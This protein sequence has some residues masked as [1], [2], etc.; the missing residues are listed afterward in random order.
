MKNRIADF[1]PSAWLPGIAGQSAKKKDSGSEP[2]S[3]LDPVE[4]LIAKHPAAALAVAFAA[5][6]ALAWWIKRK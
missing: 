2:Q 6:V 5:G 4:E 3:L 1:L